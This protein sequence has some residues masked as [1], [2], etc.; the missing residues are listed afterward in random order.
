MKLRAC[1]KCGYCGYHKESRMYFENVSYIILKCIKCKSK[2]KAVLGK[3]IGTKAPPTS[4]NR[5]TL[6][7]LKEKT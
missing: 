5:A 4:I 3:L 7:L 6:K 1:K 2:H